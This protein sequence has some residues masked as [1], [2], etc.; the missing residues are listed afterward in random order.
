MLLQEYRFVTIPRKT[1]DWGYLGCDVNIGT[2]SLADSLFLS[3]FVLSIQHSHSYFC[4]HSLLS[5]H[6]KNAKR[7]F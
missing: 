5:L 6:M 4:P 3:C 1:G 7:C 2:L